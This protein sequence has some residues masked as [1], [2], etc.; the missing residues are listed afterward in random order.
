[1]AEKRKTYS[2]AETQAQRQA[3]MAAIEDGKSFAVAAADAGVPVGRARWL[4]REGVKLQHST[5]QTSV[6]TY[7]LPEA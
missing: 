3:V 5:E 7:P 4:Y 6:S 1:M 2:E